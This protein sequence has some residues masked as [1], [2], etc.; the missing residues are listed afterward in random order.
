MTTAPGWSTTPPR[1]NVAAP[2]LARME[3]FAF[4]ATRPELNASMWPRL[5]WRGWPVALDR[6][7]RVQHASMWPRLI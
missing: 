4:S 7:A 1:F 6:H 5:I 3:L 2:D